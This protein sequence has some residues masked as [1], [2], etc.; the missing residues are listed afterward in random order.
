MCN[1][2]A[3]HSGLGQKSHCEAGCPSAPVRSAFRKRCAWGIFA[4]GSTFSSSALFI[5]HCFC[6]KLDPRLLSWAMG[7]VHWIL[8]RMGWL[9]DLNVKWIAEFENTAKD[10][11]IMSFN[12]PRKA[13]CGKYLYVRKKK[14][15]ERKEEMISKRFVDLF[16]S[17]YQKLYLLTLG[18][19]VPN[20]GIVWKHLSKS[21]LITRGL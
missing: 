4:E 21:L 20:F 12:F 17:D 6:V 8:S 10:I 16:I 5:L 2:W 3:F 15:E 14:K 9:G 1:Y 11:G 18:D 7:Y 19:S 13:H